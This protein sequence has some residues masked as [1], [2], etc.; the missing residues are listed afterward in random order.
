MTEPEV[1]TLTEAAQFLR[2]SPEGLR[3]HAFAGTIPGWQIGIRRWAMARRY[4][5]AE[6]KRYGQENKR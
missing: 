5:A 1:M 4:G 3:R 2:L 6:V